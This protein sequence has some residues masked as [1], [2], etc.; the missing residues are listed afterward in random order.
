MEG[1]GGGSSEGER[2]GCEGV[3]SGGVVRRRGVEGRGGV[4]QR[5]GK[6]MCKVNEGM[7]EGVLEV[8]LEIGG[9]R[10]GEIVR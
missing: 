2:R 1:R 10:D 7:V 4:V 6:D 5:M 3:G 8:V 9:G